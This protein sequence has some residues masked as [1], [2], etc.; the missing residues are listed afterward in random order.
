MGGVSASG[1]V[2]WL[3]GRYDAQVYAINTSI[4]KLIARNATILDFAQMMQVTA[5]DRPVVERIKA[6]LPNASCSP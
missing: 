5:L 6:A 3:S 2:L 4:G 1:H